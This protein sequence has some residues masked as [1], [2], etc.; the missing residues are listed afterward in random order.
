MTFSITRLVCTIVLANI[1]SANLFA[2]PAAQAQDVKTIINDMTLAPDAA[3]HGTENLKWGNG[4]ASPQPVPVPAKNFKGQWFQAVTAWGQVY[5]PRSG[6]SAVN[7]RCQIR[8][9]VTKLLLKNGQWKTVQF[10]AA[11]EG[12]AFAEN[13]ANNASMDA[14][15]RSEA[16]NGKGLSIIVGVGRWAGHNF[17]FWPTGGRANVDVDNVIGVYTSCEARLIKSDLNGSDDRAL[18]KNLLQ[19]GADW[20]LDKGVGWKPDWSANSGLGSMRAKWVTPNWQVFNFCSL[21]ATD[22]VTNPPVGRGRRKR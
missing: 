10:S 15:S 14:Q 8:N 4:Q 3:L 7:T 12:A 21:K 5:I 11:P 1:F 19:M 20:W 6:S 9:L 16:S 18:C 22:I 2:T 13:F 17:H